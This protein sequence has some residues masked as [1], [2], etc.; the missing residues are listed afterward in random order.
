MSSYHLEATANQQ[1]DEIYQYTLETWGEDQADRYITNLFGQFERIATR[2][3]L[4]RSVPAEFGVAAWF[5]HHNRHYIYWKEL[6]GG[7]IGIMA[8]LHERM[9]QIEWFASAYEEEE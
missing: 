3:T 2:N 7:D 4:W 6:K 1:L 9:H 8:I 5:C